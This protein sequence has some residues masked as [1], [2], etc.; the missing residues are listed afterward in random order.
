LAR[1]FA[2]HPRTS[3][4][5]VFVSVTAEEQ[6]LLGSQYYADHPTIQP[7]QMVANI[8]MDGLQVNGP[9][10]DLTVIGFG[11]SQMD[12]LITAAAA[13][14][15]RRITPDPFP[16]RGS[17]FRSDQFHFARVG[18]PVLYTGGGIDLVNGGEARGR[19]LQDAFIANRYH[20]PQDQITPDWDLTGAT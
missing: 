4:S 17:F 1:N 10:R 6:G 16:E 11:K 12:D 19:A 13:A 8:N 9:A 20:K 15:G 7:R 14:Q 2:H 5:V 3:R 18:V